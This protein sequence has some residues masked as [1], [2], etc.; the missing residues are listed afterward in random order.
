MDE[1]RLH[2]IRQH[3]V[4]LLPRPRH[5]AQQRHQLA[6][7]ADAQREGV[8]PAVERLELL[9][10]AGAE[11]DG[12]GPTLGRLQNVRIA[13]AAHEHDACRQVPSC[14]EELCK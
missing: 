11:A 6:A 5:P 2:C 7:V 8:W 9:L 1:A 4:L 3:A 10:Q 14:D 13:E 12:A